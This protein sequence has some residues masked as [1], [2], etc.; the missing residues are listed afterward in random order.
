MKRQRK[1]LSSELWL[2]VAIVLGLAASLIVSAQTRE[3]GNMQVEKA[4][5][6]AVA[7]E[8]SNIAA[9]EDV[10]K[11]V[12]EEKQQE[13]MRMCTKMCVEKCE[14]NMKDVSAAKAAIQ[15]AI[16]AIDKGDTKAAKSELKKAEKLLATVH[17]SI[18]ENVA[19]MPCVNERC[20]I[21]GKTIDMMNRPKDCTRMYKGMKVG[22]CCPN[23]PPE[24]DKLNDAE[25]EAKLKEAMPSKEVKK[26]VKVNL[27]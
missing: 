17:K 3:A 24:W 15:S 5:E 22:F 8:S 1:M 12:V 27:Y 7:G 19:M 11:E 4:K 10:L 23:C 18:E 25:K 14:T 2:I 16:E 13:K 20:P 9:G 6:A 26:D 21:S